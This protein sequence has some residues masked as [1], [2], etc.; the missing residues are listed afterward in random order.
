MGLHKKDVDERVI[1][2]Y[3]K[4]L[5][6]VDLEFKITVISQEDGLMV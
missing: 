3:L 5:C 1:L 2:R 6:R 4:V